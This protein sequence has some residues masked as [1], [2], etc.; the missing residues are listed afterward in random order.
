MEPEQM[1][2]SELIFKLNEANGRIQRLKTQLELFNR[3]QF[4]SKNT[5]VALAMVL[6][7]HPDNRLDFDVSHLESNPHLDVYTYYDEFGMK[8]CLRMKASTR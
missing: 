2:K 3:A 6:A 1:T 7:K 8:L 4:L 5:R